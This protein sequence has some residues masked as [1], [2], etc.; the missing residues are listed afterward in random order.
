MLQDGDSLEAVLGI[1][2]VA[3]VTGLDRTGVEVACAV[4]PTGHVLQ[5]T[6]GKGDSFAEARRSAVA[7]AAELWAAEQVDA[8]RLRGGPDGLAWLDARDLFSGDS[9]RLPAATLHCPPAGA[10]L[11]GDPGSAWTSNGM[12]AAPTWAAAALHALLEAVE[13][14]ALAEALPE[15]FTQEAIRARHVTRDGAP[16]AAALASRTE[17][18]GFDVYFLD[19]TGS[20]ALPTAAAVLVDRQNGPV[21]LAAGYA[22]RPTP[23]AALHAALLEAAQSRA[24][25]VHGARE[26]VAPMDRA[27]VERL[28][29]M[30][31]RA[32]PRRTVRGMPSVR[33]AGAPAALRA[34]LRRLRSA[35]FDRAAAVDLAPAGFPL[36]VAKVLVPGF[37]VS[38]LL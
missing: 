36:R 23:D 15:G 1:S 12:G 13:R 30:F 14:H 2:R 33:V 25:D 5:V 19:C 34:A 29:A 16:R 3:R 4:R 31:A 7:E 27:D 35:G 17:A 38:E 21:P 28:C 9:V 8:T 26:D 18:R 10:P 32:R 20:V 37:R 6:N 11:L 24:T 22:C